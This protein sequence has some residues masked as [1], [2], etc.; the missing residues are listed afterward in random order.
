MGGLTGDGFRSSVDRVWARR[1]RIRVVDY[2]GCIPRARNRLGHTAVRT[3][4][5]ATHPEVAERARVE[6]R[7]LWPPD[8]DPVFGDIH[9]LRHLRR[10][11]DETLRLGLH[12]R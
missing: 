3:A 9:E 5:L 11:I 2:S 1:R 10:V 4:L 8:P 7:G 12:R 6:I